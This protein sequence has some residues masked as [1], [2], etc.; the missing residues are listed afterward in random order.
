MQTRRFRLAILRLWVCWGA[1]APFHAV[2]NSAVPYHGGQLWCVGH[3]PAIIYPP[4]GS[5]GSAYLC[6]TSARFSNSY[7]I[8]GRIWPAIDR[9]ILNVSVGSVGSRQHRALAGRARPCGRPCLLR[10]Y[11]SPFAVWLLEQGVCRWLASNEVVGA[12][13]LVL[14]APCLQAMSGVHLLV[15][16]AMA[17]LIAQ[18]RAPASFG[19]RRL[20]APNRGYCSVVGM[21]S[22]RLGRPMSPLVVSALLSWRHPRLQ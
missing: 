17:A 9:R 5:A 18:C 6:C 20:K 13:R 3:C 14:A 7:G 12:L 15:W 8:W 16:C 1:R 10:R 19:R 4:Q 2:G 22:A 11:V 21:V